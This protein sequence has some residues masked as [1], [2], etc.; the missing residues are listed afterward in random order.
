MIHNYLAAFLALAFSKNTPL[1]ANLT[2]LTKIPSTGIAELVTLLISITEGKKS[3]IVVISC[4]RGLGSIQNLA[5]LL[6]HLSLSSQT[7]S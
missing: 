7:Y 1:W 6:R 3:C 2:T 4:G 5:F